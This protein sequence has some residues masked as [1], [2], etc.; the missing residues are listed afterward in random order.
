MEQFYQTCGF[1]AD[2]RAVLDKLAHDTLEGTIRG[3]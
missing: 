1:E 3:K 2:F